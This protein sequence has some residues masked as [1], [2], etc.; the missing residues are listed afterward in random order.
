[1][2]ICG[3]WKLLAIAKGYA[4]A[5]VLIVVLTLENMAAVVPVGSNNSPLNAKPLY[6]GG[7]G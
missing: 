6:E 7:E 4:V 5:S 3:P 2:I 1:M